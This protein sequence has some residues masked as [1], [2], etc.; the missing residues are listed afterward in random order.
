MQ[1]HFQIPTE[2]ANQQ[3]DG[4]KTQMMNQSSYT[5]QQIFNKKEK[6]E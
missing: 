2:Y 5:I 4:T 6:E 3:E 1:S